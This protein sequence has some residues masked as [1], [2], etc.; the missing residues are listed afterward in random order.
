MA[1]AYE[2]KRLEN[3]RRNDA[4]MASLNIHAKASLLSASTKRSRDHS[5]SLKKQQKKKEPEAPII[6]WQSP[7]SP[8]CISLSSH[9][10]SYISCLSTKLFLK[11]NIS[12]ASY[13][14]QLRWSNQVDGCLKDGF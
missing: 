4:M 12:M 13:Y 14:Q 3:I 7:F 8:I 9:L 10:F 11:V 6:K 1:T 5:K 2:R